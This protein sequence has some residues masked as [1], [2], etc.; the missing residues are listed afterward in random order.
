[1]TDTCL[2]KKE[3]CVVITGSIDVGKCFGQGTKILKYDGTVEYVENLTVGDILMGDD[4]MPRYIIETHQGESDLYEIETED[5]KRYIVNGEHLLYLYNTQTHKTTTLSVNNFMDIENKNIF[6]WCRTDVEFPSQDCQIDPY[7]FGMWVTGS[8]VN[9]PD[10]FIIDHDL[11]NSKYIPN[12]LKYS[13]KVIRQQLLN[14]I[15]VNKSNIIC[16]SERLL[17]DIIWIANSL[18]LYAKI[19]QTG[20]NLTLDVIP[21]TLFKF[22]I[23]KMK[24]EA[25]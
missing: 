5:N 8:N 17:E 18:G 22:Q 23:M 11:L 7:I 13:S 12:V 3:V 21:Q 6:R 20:Q 9:I 19:N 10:H 24:H 16:S 4:S 15:I 1:M 14:G 2:K 25:I